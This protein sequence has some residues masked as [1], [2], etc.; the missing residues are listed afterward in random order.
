MIIIIRCGKCGKLRKKINKVCIELKNR[1]IRRQ[2]VLCKTVDKS[3][4][5]VLKCPWLINLNS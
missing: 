3:V 1:K 4:K 5:T 2:S